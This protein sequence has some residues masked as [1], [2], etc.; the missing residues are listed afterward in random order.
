[1]IADE[2]IT[3]FG[4][5][6]RWFAC[7][8]EGVVPDL[9]SVAK[10]ITSGYIPLSAS[11]ARR[12]LAD[13]FPDDAARRRTCT[14]TPTRR[15]RSRARRRS[16]TSRSWSRTTWSRTPRRWAR[17]CSTGSSSAVGKQRDRRRGARP[18]PHGVRRARGARR[19]GPAA[20]P[21][22]RVAA[23]DRKAWERGRDRLRAGAASCGWRR[24]SASPPA[25]VDQLVDIVA[26][27]IEELEEELR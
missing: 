21:Q 11:I 26:A 2:V 15:I 22:E 23:L 5:T 17:G 20:R 27:S 6:G 13:A 25:E 18:R 10:G 14:P 7:E 1:M 9:M 8:H 12:R 16:P 19:L 4:R 3:G 24:R